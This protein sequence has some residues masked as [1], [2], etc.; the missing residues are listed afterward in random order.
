M[1][2][3]IVECG[4]GLGLGRAQFL[5][6][7]GN[8]EY[9]RPTTMEFGAADAGLRRIFSLVIYGAK[10]D[11]PEPLSFL[12]CF[13]RDFERYNSRVAAAGAGFW[14][15][16]LAGARPICPAVFGDVG[17]GFQA[18]VPRGVVFDGRPHFVHGGGGD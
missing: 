1:L 10:I 12:N 7:T 14:L 13:N 15:L 17:A 2:T 18:D 4:P 11:Y 8:E 5:M 16:R 9:V 3:L 6:G